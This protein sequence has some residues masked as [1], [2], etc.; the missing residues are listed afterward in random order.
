MIIEAN[1]LLKSFGDIDTPIALKFIFVTEPDDRVSMR[2][3]SVESL[4][5]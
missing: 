4:A 2:L 3:V 5:M 1:A